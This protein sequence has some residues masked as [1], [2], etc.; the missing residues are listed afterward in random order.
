MRSVLSP[1]SD[2]ALLFDLRM[3]FQLAVVI[4]LRQIHRQWLATRR[5]A[6]LQLIVCPLMS[7]T[8]MIVGPRSRFSRI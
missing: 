1:S 6:G 5:L 7:P 4:H 8:R 2:A 3:N